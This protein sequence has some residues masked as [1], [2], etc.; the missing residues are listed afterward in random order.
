MLKY[1]NFS[2]DPGRCILIKDTSEYRHY[3]TLQR[4]YL[5]VKLAHEKT[6][7]NSLPTTESASAKTY[8]AIKCM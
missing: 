8:Q 4:A 6:T 2:Y 5:E 7:S 1:I 3:K